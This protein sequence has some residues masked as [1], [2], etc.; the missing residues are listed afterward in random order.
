[1]KNRSLIL[2]AGVFLLFSFVSSDTKTFSFEFP[3]RKHIQLKISAPSKWVIDKEKKGEDMYYTNFSKASEKDVLFSLLFFKLNEYEQKS[4][5][6]EMGLEG[7]PL[8]PATYFLSNN[9]TAKYET[10]NKSWED[11]AFYYRDYNIETFGTL[12]VHQKNMKAYCMYD[13][14][15]FV[16]VHLSKPNYSDADSALMR[17]ILNS[18]R[19]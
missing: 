12:K 18:L 4:M 1:M 16:Q 13:K 11:T 14:D 15:L 3:K 10:D 7:N 9:N 19:K 17:S 2:I 8:L 6:G 5:I